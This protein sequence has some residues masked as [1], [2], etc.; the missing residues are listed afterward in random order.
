MTSPEKLTDSPTRLPCPFCGGA[1][2]YF[3]Y[4][5][6]GADWHKVRCNACPAIVEAD[7]IETRDEAIT[8]WNR[9]A[10]PPPSGEAGEVAYWHNGIG[11]VMTPAQKAEQDEVCASRFSEAL[12]TLPTIR[13]TTDEVGTARR[14]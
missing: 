2:R 14:A 12:Y 4:S 10:S 3:K 6:D 9:R 7:D 8:H 11:Q 5:E 13:G 1:A